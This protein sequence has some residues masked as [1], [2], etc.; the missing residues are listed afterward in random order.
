MVSLLDIYPTLV[1]LA[2]LEAPSILEGNSLEPLL[3]QPNRPWEYP[4][5]TTYRQGNHAIQGQRYRYIRYADG[6]EELYDHQMDPDEWFN[7]AANP[8]LT[9]IKERL[10]RH[11]PND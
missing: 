3:D 10:A 4:A 7:L 11:L 6:S 9:P 2:G 5:I 1:E 8:Q